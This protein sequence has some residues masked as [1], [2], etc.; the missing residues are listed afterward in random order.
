[1]RLIQL[2]DE[3]AV[4]LHGVMQNPLSDDPNTANEDPVDAANRRAVY[5]ATAD[6]VPYLTK[7]GLDSA[8]LNISRAQD[9]VDKAQGQVEYGSNQWHRLETADDRLHDAL[10]ALGE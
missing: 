10:G 2:T 4:W 3:Q 1:M 8:I 5:E 7:Q 6:D 9:L